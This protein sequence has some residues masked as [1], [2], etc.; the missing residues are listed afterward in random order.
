MFQDFISLI[1]QG[2]KLLLAE[3][4]YANDVIFKIKLFLNILKHGLELLH[5]SVS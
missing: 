1:N 2:E 5:L 3:N 4:S